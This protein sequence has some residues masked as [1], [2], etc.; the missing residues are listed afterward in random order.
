MVVFPLYCLALFT[1]NLAII[2]LSCY[3]S[4][5]EHLDHFVTTKINLAY[6][7]KKGWQEG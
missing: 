2:A 7:N 6:Y 3:V 4:I 5:L 1:S